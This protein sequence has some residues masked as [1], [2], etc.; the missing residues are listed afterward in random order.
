MLRVGLDLGIYELI[1]N[2]TG[3]VTA[4]QV[5]EKTKADLVLTERIMRNLAAIT[6]V[7]EVGASVYRANKV[8]K[9]FASPKGIHL[10][11]FA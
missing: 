10:G 2:S 5:A 1:A 3:P 9:A 7:D 8:T 11:N 6:H 4:A